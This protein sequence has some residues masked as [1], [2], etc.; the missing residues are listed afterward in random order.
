MPPRTHLSLVPD[1]APERKFGV[2]NPDGRPPWEWLGLLAATVFVPMAA[3][4]ADSLH[5]DLHPED[6]DERH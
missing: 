5:I 3:Q 1:D 2:L 4:L 6:G